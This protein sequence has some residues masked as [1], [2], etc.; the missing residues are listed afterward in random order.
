METYKE[1]CGDPSEPSIDQ[2]MCELHRSVT[3]L[4][5]ARGHLLRHFT[6]TRNTKTAITYAFSTTCTLFIGADAVWNDAFS[7]RSGRDAHR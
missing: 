2:K 5:G 1:E 6:P 4:D 3:N 7:T